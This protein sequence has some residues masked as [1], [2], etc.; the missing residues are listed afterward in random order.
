MKSFFIVITHF[1]LIITGLGIYPIF[2]NNK[3]KKFKSFSRQIY[4]IKFKITFKFYKNIV[5]FKLA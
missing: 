1:L 3:S 4:P 5:K 2:Q